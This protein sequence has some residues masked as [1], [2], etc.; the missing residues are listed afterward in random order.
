MAL[1]A[2]AAAAAALK[3]QPSPLT[4]MSLASPSHTTHDY[5]PGS[6]AGCAASMSQ[7]LPTPD[8]LNSRRAELDDAQPDAG[9]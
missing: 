5:T 1:A 9:E 8:T 3:R 7:E 6:I 4:P 2:Q